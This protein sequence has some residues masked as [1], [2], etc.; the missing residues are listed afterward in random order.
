MNA[1]IQ[2]ILFLLLC[3]PAYEHLKDCE[4]NHPYCQCQ[5]NRINCILRRRFIK[6]TKL[7]TSTKV[8]FTYYFKTTLNHYSSSFSKSIGSRSF[9]L[10]FFLIF[11]IFS[12]YISIYYCNLSPKYRCLR[13]LSLRNS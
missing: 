3:L 2:Q 5:A 10:N 8:K 9:S 4:H 13:I 7:I 11:S 12:S 1:T 6:S